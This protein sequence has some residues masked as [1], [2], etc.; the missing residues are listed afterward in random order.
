MQAE[1]AAAQHQM[2]AQQ[3]QEQAPAGT[4]QPPNPQHF[5]VRGPPEMTAAAEVAYTGGG[6][7]SGL[8]GAPGGQ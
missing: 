5:P 1:A 3:Q 7:I 4:A 6:G 2:A 8:G